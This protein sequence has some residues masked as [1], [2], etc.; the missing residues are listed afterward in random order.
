MHESPL[1][2]IIQ[3]NALKTGNNCGLMAVHLSQRSGIAMP[4]IKAELN[5]LF[6]DGKIKVRDGV[7]GKLIF[8][9]TAK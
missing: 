4:E 9:K 6:V 8:I 2:K 7:H 3:E 1:F 5:Q